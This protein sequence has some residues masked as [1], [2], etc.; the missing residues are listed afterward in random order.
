[1]NNRIAFSCLRSSDCSVLRSASRT[2]S[3]RRRTGAVLAELRRGEFPR[4]RLHNGNSNRVEWR[5]FG[6]KV[7]FI[8]SLFHGRHHLPPFHQREWNTITTSLRPKDVEVFSISGDG[9]RVSAFSPSASPFPFPFSVFGEG[10]GWCES[11]YCHHVPW[12]RIS[13]MHGLC[14]YGETSS[15]VWKCAKGRRLINSTEMNDEFF[16]EKRKGRSFLIFVGVEN[17]NFSIKG[18][19]CP[20]SAIIQPRIK[21]R[22]I[23]TILARILETRDN[24]FNPLQDS[25]NTFTHSLIISPSSPSKQWEFELNFQSTHDLSSD[26]SLPGS[27]SGYDKSLPRVCHRNCEISRVH[28]ERGSSLLA[29]AKIVDT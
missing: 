24:R 20:R 4:L 17:N 9:P 11:R 23:N 16:Q 28:M 29:K 7:V 3:W 25:T 12:K 14:L 8:R 18:W 22:L 15:V 2:C 1:M 26:I 10:Q 6:R 21:F 5:W 19:W 27:S 13:L